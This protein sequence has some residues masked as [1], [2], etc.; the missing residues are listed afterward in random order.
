M[1]RSTQPS[2]S[3]GVRIRDAQ[4]SDGKKAIFA[5][6]AEVVVRGT[7]PADSAGTRDY[8]YYLCAYL[9]R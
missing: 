8:V 2:N 3:S 1:M 7:I 5:Q 6:P 4:L 9:F